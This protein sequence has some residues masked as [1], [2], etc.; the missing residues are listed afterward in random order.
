MEDT[1]PPHP[2]KSDI[3]R[4][5]RGFLVEP[6]LDAREWFAEMDSMGPD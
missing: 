1:R 2:Q 4:V 3:R 5:G 6:I